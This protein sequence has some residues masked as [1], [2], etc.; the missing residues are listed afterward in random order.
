[1]SRWIDKA[2]KQRL[3]PILRLQKETT[4]LLI[5]FLPNL[6]FPKMNCMHWDGRMN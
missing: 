1:M 6:V 5:V 2:L 4:K 3:N